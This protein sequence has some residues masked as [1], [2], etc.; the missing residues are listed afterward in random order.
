VAARSGAHGIRLATPVGFLEEGAPSTFVVVD[1][2]SFGSVQR[3]ESVMKLFL[4]SVLLS[5]AAMVVYC[6]GPSRAEAAGL[7]PGI[8]AE[9]NGDVDADGTRNINDAV[10]MLQYIFLGGPAPRQLACEPVADFHNG[11]VNGS[12]EM[13]IS[14]PIYLL[15]WLFLGDVDTPVDGC[16]ILPL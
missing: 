9:L 4:G 11:D 3:K 10:Y 14:D 13:D 12:G 15:H 8:L 1:R 2:F 5:L 16:P 7:V 6:V